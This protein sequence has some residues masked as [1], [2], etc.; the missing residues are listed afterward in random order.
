MT[1]TI[2]G[3]EYPIYIGLD[4]LDYLDSIYF[5]EEKGVKFGQGLSMAVVHLTT[6]NPVVLYHLIKAGTI[7]EKS[8]P[9][10]GDIK[11]YLE[12]EADCEALCADF[13]SVLETAHLT[14]SKLAKLSELTVT[15]K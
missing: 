12:T 8:K 1:I 14:K 7:T 6:E 9:S 3:K 5:I 4:F 13:L 11:K 2:N 10:N 15:G